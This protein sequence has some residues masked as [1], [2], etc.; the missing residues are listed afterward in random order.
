MVN[1]WMPATLAARSARAFQNHDLR[2]MQQQERANAP[3]AKRALVYAGFLD[4]PINWRSVFIEDDKA[5]ATVDRGQG[6]HACRPV[7]AVRRS[8]RAIM[9]FSSAEKVGPGGHPILR[10]LAATPHTPPSV[11]DQSSM[12][13]SGEFPSL[14]WTTPNVAFGRVS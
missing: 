10:A 4:A 3:P 11:T 12:T 5:D 7:H 14:N 8:I 13:A 6:Q 1:A 9:A 2:T